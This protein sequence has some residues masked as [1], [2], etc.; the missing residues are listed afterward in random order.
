MTGNRTRKPPEVRRREILDAAIAIGAERGL[1]RIN[2]REVADR[3]GVAPGLIHHYFPSVDE[4]LAESF[5]SWA[6]SSLKVLQELSGSKSPRMAL[7][8]TVA[9]LSPDQRIWHDAL[10]SASRH[11]QLRDRARSLS[12]D[13]LAHVEGLI[14]A[15]VEMKQFTA[16]DPQASA[17]RIILVLDGMVAMMH[18]LDMIPPDQLATIVGPVVERELELAPGSFT[19]LVQAVL[20]AGDVPGW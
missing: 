4:L 19:E 14:R 15:G 2:V 16:P 17:W 6:D 10:S 7:A 11:T 13:Y 5:G 9:N 12:E 20:N 8:L 18:I 3:C 1:D